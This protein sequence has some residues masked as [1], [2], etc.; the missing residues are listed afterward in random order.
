MT[1][2][3]IPFNWP[4]QSGRELGYITEVIQ[5]GVLSGDGPFTQR[6]QAVLQTAF[7]HNHTLLTTS[8]TDALEMCALLLDLEPGDEVI[9]PSFTF[10][11]TA[12]AFLI[13]GAKPV[14]VDIEPQTLNIDPRLIRRAITERTRAIIVVHYAGVGCDMEEIG[15][16][17][18]AHGLAVIEDNA[19]GLG[20]FYRGQVLGS[21]GGMATLSFHETKNFTCGEGGALIVNDES[22]LERA[23]IIREKGTDRSRFF[24]GQ[25]DK[26][27]WVDVG[28]SFLPSEILAAHL[29]AQLEA[30]A[31]VQAKREA[32]WHRYN[33]ELAQWADDCGVVLPTVPADRQQAFHMFYML[34]PSLDARR[35][36]IES[37]K[38]E[39]MLAVFHYLPLHLSRMGRGLGYSDGDCPVTEQVCDCLVRLPFFTGLASHD[40]DDV[41]EAVQKVSIQ[42]M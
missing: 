12:N 15:A 20:G 8:C 18:D 19:H 37:L 7:G 3:R 25:V 31:T 42:H 6:C 9:V 16:I 4:W 32:I 23:E 5:S 13:H 24:R 29:L 22:L 17:A 10:V 41:I 21:L 14:F 26:Y 2:Y 28:S 40:Q 1:N 11:S 36:L 30:K 34:M 38:Q 33:D 27:G 39:S 35:S